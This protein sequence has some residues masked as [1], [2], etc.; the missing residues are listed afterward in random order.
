LSVTTH[1]GISKAE[2]SAHYAAQ[3]VNKYPEAHSVSSRGDDL[4]YLNYLN[5]KKAN[6]E[7]YSTTLKQQVRIK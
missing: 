1:T 7:Q 4:S 5:I 3:F 2:G 6:Y